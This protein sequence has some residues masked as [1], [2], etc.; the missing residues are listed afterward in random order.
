MYIKKEAKILY[1]ELQER[2]GT[3]LKKYD[4][5]LLDKAFKYA[6]KKHENQTTASGDIY[7]I[8][9]LQTSIILAWVYADFPSIVAGLLHDIIRDTKI[10]QEDIEEKFWKEIAILVWGV[11]RVSEIPYE[12]GMTT[13]DLE[14]LKK[15]FK[16]AGKDIRVFLIKICER[17]DLIRGLEFLEEDVRKEKAIETL[18]IY[19]PLIKVF[20]IWKYIWNVEDLC[21]KYL[22]QSEF[23]RLNKIISKQKAHLENRIER[24]KGL[25]FEHLVEKGIESEIEGRIKTIYSISKKLQKK[26]IPLSGVYDLIALRVIVD[27]KKQC[28]ISLSII[29]SLFKSKIG[30]TKDYISAPKP[31]GYQSIHTTVSDND[32]NVFEVQIQTKQMYRF[33]MFGLASHQ[34]YKGLSSKHESFPRWMKKLL[35]QQ[36]EALFGENFIEN[37]RPNE[38]KNTIIC[39]TPK[40]KEIELPKKA[41]ILDFAFKVH[42]DIWKKSIWAWV[43]NEYI[44]NLVYTLT[45]WDKVELELGKQESDYPVKYL[46][47]LRTGIAQ[48]SLKHMFKNKS[49]W[50]RQSLWKHLIED[51]MELVWYKPFESMPR[52]IKENVFKNFSIDSKDLLYL[53]LGSWNIDVDKVVNYIY[54]LKQD[55]SKYKTTVSLKIIFKKKNNKNIHYLFDVFHNLNIQVINIH[56]KWSW[57]HAD[58]HVTDLNI[59]HELLAELSRL[60]NV[61]KV[62]RTFSYRVWLFLFILSFISIY[63]IFWP[64]ILFSIKEALENITWAYKILF[65]SSVSLFVFLLYFFKYIARITLPGIIKK[66]AF[67]SGIFWLNTFILASVIWGSVNIYN[68]ADSIFL[69]SATLLLYGFTIFEFLS[70]KDDNEG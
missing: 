45:D 52:I 59:L 44:D 6:Y 50:K 1:G 54:N 3:Y 48:K 37:I 36:K 24:F 42:S 51:R 31:N 56:Y 13:Q 61:S 12:D 22:E 49:R 7:A 62:K 2:I 23:N 10:T 17:I 33:N 30:R 66:N 38:L 39:T 58:V 34:C 55:D 64:A 16:I 35:S 32:G 26:H 67:W 4:S 46:S 19:V 43:N 8:H 47:F 18:D 28:Y 40:W 57:A 14:F 5:K 21:Y 65:Y 27:T 20:G 69:L 60:P 15:L 9:L 70:C 63:I 68:S 41:T 11:T 53:E 29:H 25:I